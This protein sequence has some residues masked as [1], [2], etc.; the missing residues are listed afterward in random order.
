MCELH[1]Q[2]SKQRLRWGT[3]ADKTQIL[4]AGLETVMIRSGEGR[5]QTTA[6]STPG[7][8]CLGRENR[9]FRPGQ[10]SSQG[11]RRTQSWVMR[12]QI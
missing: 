11:I 7:R 8:G 4:G 1:N 3:Y 2:K 6:N 9:A 10:A 12:N 5:Q